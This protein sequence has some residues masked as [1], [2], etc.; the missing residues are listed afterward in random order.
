MKWRQIFQFSLYIPP[1]PEIDSIIVGNTKLDA[2]DAVD[3]N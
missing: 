1:N 3:E 2:D